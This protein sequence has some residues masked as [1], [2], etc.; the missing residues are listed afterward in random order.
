MIYWL[1]WTCMFTFF[2]RKKV[3]HQAYFISSLWMPIFRSAK[4]TESL[5]GSG[6]DFRWTGC[7]G[8]SR[9]APCILICECFK[10]IFQSRR[11]RP[12]HFDSSLIPRFI[13]ATK[14]GFHKRLS[15]WK[16]RLIQRYLF[17]F[18]AKLNTKVS[19]MFYILY[20]NIP[21]ATFSFQE[22]L[23]SI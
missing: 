18:E 12:F 17:K 15:W 1:R 9:G 2:S 13:I 3:D 19:R 7:R 11:R 10:R 4:K 16:I 8:L 14:F 22:N 21:P 5:A 20:I 23:I 6:I